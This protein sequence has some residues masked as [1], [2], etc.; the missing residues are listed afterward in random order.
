L[1]VKKLLHLLIPKFS[2]K[3][4]NSLKYEKSVYAHFVKYVREVA[5]G[6]RV[7]KL[8][9]ILEFATCASEEPLLGFALSPSIEFVEATC[10]S[11]EPSYNSDE[12]APQN[13][14][15]L[16]PQNQVRFF[17]DADIVVPLFFWICIKLG[18]QKLKHWQSLLVEY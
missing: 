1:S 18:K 13:Q 10:A 5:S 9:N 11:R 16:L 8:E 15:Q 7:T 2:E 14:V 12:R 4:S 17:P 3:G 6:R